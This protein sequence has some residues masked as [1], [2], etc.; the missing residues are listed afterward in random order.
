MTFQA[1]AAILA[2]L[3]LAGDPFS[4]LGA[5]L[6]ISSEERS[7]LS[8]GQTIMR[9]LS[10]PSDQVGVL[11]ASR[12]AADPISLIEQARQIENLKRGSFV[13]GIHRF[14][15]PPQLSDLD[16]LVLSPRDAEAAAN[17]RVGKCSFK[18]TA[19]EIAMFSGPAGSNG[20]AHPDPNAAFRRILFSRVQS[21]LA[22]GLPSLPPVANRST[23][24]CLAQAFD[25]L[26]TASPP[27]PGAP[28]ATD[29]LRDARSAEQVESFLYWSQELYG[30]KPVVV[31]THVGLLPPRRAGDPALVVGKQ[32]FASRYMTASLAMT[33]IITDAAS[34]AQYLLY[35]NRTAV[36][37]LGGL[38]GPIKRAILESQLRGQVPEIITK[39][40]TR[41]ERV[42]PATV[43]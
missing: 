5:G 28:C 30:G 27:A 12:I 42:A 6:T 41:L 19:A 26:L 15:D 43:R 39:L 16:G 13:I 18:M 8:R 37:L 22:G 38:L 40:R 25:T 32:I 3:L 7:A 10:G 17:C 31:V 23:P 29:W 21:Y 36:D 11:A 4:Q 1:S 14:S 9:T 20:A 2:A 33:A 24:L 35:V 34:G